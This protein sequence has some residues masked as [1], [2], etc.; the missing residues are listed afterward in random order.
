MAEISESD[1]YRSTEIPNPRGKPIVR[2]EKKSM[3]KE[4][5]QKQQQQQQPVVETPPPPQ[6]PIPELEKQDEPEVTPFEYDEN[7]ELKAKLVPTVYSF[8]T[9]KEQLEYMYGPGVTEEQVIKMFGP[10]KYREGLKRV[11][12]TEG[13]EISDIH[14]R[15]SGGKNIVGTFCLIWINPYSQVL[16][17]DVTVKDV[18][19]DVKT[20]KRV[21]YEILFGK[22]QLT[23]GNLTKLVI[24]S[25][26]F[27]IEPGVE[28]NFYNSGNTPLVVRLWY[29]GHVDLRDRYFPRARKIEE[30]KESK[31]EVFDARL[32][33]SRPVTT[34]YEPK[35]KSDQN[36]V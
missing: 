29:D 30:S 11:I 14:I 8:A 20:D 35:A 22:G 4:Q 19:A 32:Q 7:K 12:R 34:K 25:D 28:H 24:K 17:L 23:I 27:W 5:Q 1:E 13:F 15:D 18:P 2:E 36:F 26:I 16:P 33:K 10:P 21:I 31:R 9:R 6:T 3:L